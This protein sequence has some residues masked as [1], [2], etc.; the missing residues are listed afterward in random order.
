[1][2][3]AAPLPRNCPRCTLP[4]KRLGS[5]WCCWELV[6]LRDLMALPTPPTMRELTHVHFIGR[7]AGSIDR[8]CRRY[9]FKIPSRRDRTRSKRC[10][11]CRTLFAGASVVCSRCAQPSNERVAA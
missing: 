5:E 1:M 6:Q 11:S 3:E 8:A 9:G 10:P 4:S 7:S 2:S